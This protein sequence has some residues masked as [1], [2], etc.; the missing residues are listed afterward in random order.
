MDEPY[1]ANLELGGVVW[2]TLD[3]SDTLECKASILIQGLDELT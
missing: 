3:Y 1:M 2:S